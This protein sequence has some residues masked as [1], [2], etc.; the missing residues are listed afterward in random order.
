LIASIPCNVWSGDL[1]SSRVLR[2]LVP[3][4]RAKS[5]SCPAARST[6]HTPSWTTRSDR[7]RSR[8]RQRHR[9]TDYQAGKQ[10]FLH[11]G[12]LHASRYPSGQIHFTWMADACLRAWSGAPGFAQSDQVM[13]DGRSIRG[14]NTVDVA[15]VLNE[16]PL[17][18]WMTWYNGWR[19]RVGR[20]HPRPS[21]SGTRRSLVSAG[22]IA[23]TSTPVRQRWNIPKSDW[24][25]SLSWSR[26]AC[27]QV[28]LPSCGTPDRSRRS[29]RCASL[30]RPRVHRC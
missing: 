23:G 7:D 9:T 15:S 30:F 3:I 25:T 5:Q 27:W 10:A 18:D 21:A 17:M 2:R 14:Q 22:R 19:S 26:S 29:R 28:S 16:K 24:S 4:I 1:I 11:G 20:P 8:T 13:L 6:V 12:N